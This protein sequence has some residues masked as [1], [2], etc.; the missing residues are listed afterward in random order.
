MLDLKEKKKKTHPLQGDSSTIMIGFVHPTETQVLV[1]RKK[2][3]I[4]FR[5]EKVELPK[6]AYQEPEHSGTLHVAVLK[7]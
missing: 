4:S 1:G 5:T 7:G 6:E 2:Y 3:G